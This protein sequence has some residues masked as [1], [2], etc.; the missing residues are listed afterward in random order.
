MK[1][2]VLLT[3]N[4]MN[5][6][7]FWRGF[8]LTTLTLASSFALSPATR[9][10]CEEGCGANFNTFLG[11][12]ALSNNTTGGTNTAIGYDALFS[13]TTGFGNTATGPKRAR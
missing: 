5:R 4:S 13:N 6:T 10:A 11:V 7:L 1:T 12:G 8:V 2:N 9:A 3:T